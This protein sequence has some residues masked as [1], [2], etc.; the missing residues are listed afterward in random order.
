MNVTVRQRTETSNS[1][2][3]LEHVY[4][5]IYSVSQEE[6]YY[7]ITKDAQESIFYCHKAEDVIDIAIV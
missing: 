7:W 3:A 1:Q 5:D 4:N 2:T 6:G